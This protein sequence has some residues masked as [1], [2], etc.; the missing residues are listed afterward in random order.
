MYIV[1]EIW[2]CSQIIHKFTGLSI[3]GNP[4]FFKHMKTSYYNR[5]GDNIVFEK[6][7]DDKVEMSGHNYLRTGY[8]KEGTDIEFVDPAGG[9]YIGIGMNVGTYFESKKKMIIESIE[10]KGEIIILNIKK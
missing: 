5:Y 10:P 2:K 6:T 3:M 4:Y 9:P 8:N 7:E 1:E